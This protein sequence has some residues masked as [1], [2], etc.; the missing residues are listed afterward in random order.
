MKRR[1]VVLSSAASDDM[2]GLLN[3]AMANSGADAAIALDKVLDTALGSLETLAHRGRV[4][5][6]L[7][8]RG[9]STYREL[10][11]A[12]YRMIYR[13]VSDEVWVLAVVD[14]R[15]DLHALLYE[16]ARR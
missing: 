2:A 1:K 5:P 12:P 13:V 9:I 8:V 6:E 3:Y 14:G 10:V 15:R 4:V 11:R 16:R 7:Q